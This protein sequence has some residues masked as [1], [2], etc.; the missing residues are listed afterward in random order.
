LAHTQYF[1][2]QTLT[3]VK[4]PQKLF[5]LDPLAEISGSGGGGGHLFGWHSTSLKV[6]LVS[7]KTKWKNN[8]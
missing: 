3:T 2:I 4:T 5:V 6:V 1:H 8:L 7:L